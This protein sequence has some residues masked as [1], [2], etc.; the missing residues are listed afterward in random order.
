VRTYYF[1]VKGKTSSKELTRVKVPKQGIG[2][3]QPVVAMK[4]L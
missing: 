2:T 3:E 1:D 4:L